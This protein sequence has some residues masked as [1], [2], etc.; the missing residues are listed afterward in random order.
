MAAGFNFLEVQQSR[1]RRLAPPPLRPQPA[2]SST[3]SQTSRL[4][5]EVIKYGG[6]S[7]SSALLSKLVRTFFLGLTTVTNLH[8]VVTYTVKSSNSVLPVHGWAIQGGSW[9][10]SGL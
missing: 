1:E 6:Q 10:S 2:D 4:A 7:N 9:L 5:W 8:A 3:L